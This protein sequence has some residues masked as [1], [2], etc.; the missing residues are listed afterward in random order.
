MISRRDV[1]LGCGSTSLDYD[2][3]IIQNWLLFGRWLL[4]ATTLLI[5]S[6]ILD[7]GSLNS[8]L[9][10]SALLFCSPHNQS[11]FSH[12]LAEQSPLVHWQNLLQGFCPLQP[13]ATGDLRARPSIAICW[14]PVLPPEVWPS[15]RVA[16]KASVRWKAGS[17]LL[18]W[19]SSWGRV[20]K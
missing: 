18:G 12:E 10:C 8:H 13:P 19:W 20:A 16:A 5:W 11:V 17:D 7:A 9:S 15:S 4:L 2:A 6:P 14:E 3:S 1:P